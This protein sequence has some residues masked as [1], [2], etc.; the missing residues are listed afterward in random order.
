[1]KKQNHEIF[2]NIANIEGIL[3]S[4]LDNCFIERIT[5]GIANTGR[6]NAIATKMR[7]ISIKKTA[8]SPIA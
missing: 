3:F 6:S 2:S 8:N 7:G 4:A 1:M 5:P